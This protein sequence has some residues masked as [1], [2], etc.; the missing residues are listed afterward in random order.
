[1]KQWTETPN[2]KLYSDGGSKPNPGKGGYGIILSYK[3]INKEFSQGYLNTTNNRMELLGVIAGLER[4][5]TKSNVQVYTDSKY[6]VNGIEKGW[7]KKW[8]RNGW[9]RNKTDKAINS[10]LW[11]RLL[12]LIDKHKVTL[13]WVRGHNGHAQNERCDELAT[14]ARLKNNLREDSGFVEA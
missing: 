10:D 11:D 9:Y 3:G 12:T 14:E 2:I 6:V 8:K 1:M 13:N 7:A 4:I 5:K